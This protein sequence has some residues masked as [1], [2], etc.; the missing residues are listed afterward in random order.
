MSSPQDSSP[1]N[2]H[3]SPVPEASIAV[4]APGHQSDSDLSDVQEPA[5]ARDSSSS[6]PSP[7]P[8]HL[9]EQVIDDL[10]GQEAAESDG[11]SE[12]NASDDA[13]FDMEDDIPSP[14]TDGAADE[15]DEVDDAGSNSR[16]SSPAPKRKAG[17]D[18]D[19]FIKANPV[20]YGLRRSVRA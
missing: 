12:A 9:A 11:S 20:L 18:E 4:A 3:L 17:V 19:E 1:V 14:Q 13:D 6:S 5:A 10:D 16:A 8:D 7:Q 2:G 15:A